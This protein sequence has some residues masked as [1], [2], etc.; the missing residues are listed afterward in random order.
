[1][2]AAGLSASLFNS[3]SSFSGITTPIAI[4]Y[5]VHPMY[6]FNGAL[7]F[8]GI[9]ALLAMASYALVGRYDTSD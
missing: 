7:I 8:V 5:L 1:M 3:F 2:N 9:H 6:S 4:G